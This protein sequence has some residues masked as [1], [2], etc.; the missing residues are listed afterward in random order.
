MEALVLVQES[1]LITLIEDAVGRFLKV[2]TPKSEPDNV[3]GTKEAVIFLRENGY[4]ISESLFTKHTAR[5]TIPAQSEKLWR[6]R[7]NFQKRL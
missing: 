3:S 1:R 7:L 5:G 6:V 2:E 4:E